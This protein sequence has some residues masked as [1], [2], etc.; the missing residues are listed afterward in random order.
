LI[1]IGYGRIGGALARLFRRAGWAVTVHTPSEASAQRAR[2]DGFKAPDAEAWRHAGAA[3]LCVPDTSVGEAARDTAARLSPEAALVHC[4]GALTLDALG[5]PGARQR[6]SFH[7]LCAVS[8]PHDSLAGCAV[9]L[10]ADGESLLRLL[11]RLARG[12]GLAPIEV[13]ESGRA[14][15]HAGAVL[16]AGG[17]VTLASAAVEA[18][19][20]AGLSRETALRALLPL[21]RSA[22]KGIESRGLTHA[23]TGPVVRGDIATL[24]AHLAALPPDLSALYRAVSARAL[25]LVP[26]VQGSSRLA[27]EELLR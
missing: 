3:L 4:A 9:A 13:P 24:R 21:M 7:P 23:L 5:G 26:A 14:A 17:L 20:S 10:A 2:R 22:L 6:G 19:A 15:Y 18:V 1:V 16:A 25:A 11:R 27:I 8:D 12:A